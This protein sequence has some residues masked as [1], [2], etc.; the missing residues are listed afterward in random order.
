MNLRSIFMQ[1][2]SGAHSAEFTD[3]AS[4][5]PLGQ[6]FAASYELTFYFHAERIWCSPC[7]SAEFTDKAYRIPRWAKTEF[8]VASFLSRLNVFYAI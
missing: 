6:N 5:S 4:D 1:N 8:I 2:E 3:K 7:G